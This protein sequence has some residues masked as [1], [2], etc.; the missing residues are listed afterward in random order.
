VISNQIN[1]DRMEKVASLCTLRKYLLKFPSGKLTE[2]LAVFVHEDVPQ[3][4][5]ERGLV[6][7]G[8]TIGGTILAQPGP[9]RC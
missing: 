1:V 7:E 8:K 3:D 9:G 5:A 2:I 6:P 4:S